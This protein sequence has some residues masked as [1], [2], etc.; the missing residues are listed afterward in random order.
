MKVKDFLAYVKSLEL[1]DDI[2]NVYELEMILHPSV[3]NGSELIWLSMNDRLIYFSTKETLL[4]EGY[5]EE[6]ILGMENRD[7]V[8]HDIS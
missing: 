2:K 1:D 3:K 6:V 5:S 8:Y 4:E 7:Y